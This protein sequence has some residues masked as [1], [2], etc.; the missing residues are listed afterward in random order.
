MALCDICGKGPAPEHGGVTVYRQNATGQPGIWRCRAHA[1]APVETELQQIVD[2]IEGR[3]LD[4]ALK[5]TNG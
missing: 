5:G 3:G 4:A 1:D 2:A